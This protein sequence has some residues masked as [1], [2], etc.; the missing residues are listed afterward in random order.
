MND[1]IRLTVPPLEVSHA[2]LA[3]G[4]QQLRDGGA[5]WAA[6]EAQHLP[7]AGI[8]EGLGL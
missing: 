3:G 8:A 1:I 5:I 4:V 6:V 2:G 7:Q